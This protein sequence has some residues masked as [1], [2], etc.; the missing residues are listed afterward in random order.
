MDDRREFTRLFVPVEKRLHVLITRSGLMEDAFFAKV[1]NLSEGGI[2]LGMQK[3]KMNKLKVE[4]I[5]LVKQIEGDPRLVLSDD[6][7]VK[8]IWVIEH[9][10]LDNIAVGCEFLDLPPIFLESIREFIE[11]EQIF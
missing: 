7:K 1:M 6:L 3:R 5:L 11:S 2:G 9:D 8:V 4:D 10:L